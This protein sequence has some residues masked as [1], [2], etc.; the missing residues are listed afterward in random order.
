M[1][2]WGSFR[3]ALGELCRSLGEA[4]GSH[5]G[6][7]RLPINTLWGGF[8]VAW[9]GCIW[10]LQIADGK[11][12]IARPVALFGFSF[13]L[14]AFQLLPDCGFGWLARSPASISAFCF[15][16]SA[17]AWRRL[18]P[19]VQGSR[20]RV[21][22]S[23]F[24]VHHKNTEYNSPLP[25]PPGWSG[26]TLVPPWTYPGTIAPPQNPIFDQ[27]SL[28][29][30]VSCGSSTGQQCQGL[31]VGCWRLNVPRLFMHHVSFLALSA[32]TPLTFSR[33]MI[34]GSWLLQTPRSPGGSLGGARC[35]GRMRPS[36]S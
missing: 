31:D 34:P 18:C 11:W 4:L 23:R 21:Q 20:F 6:R 2:L 25:P 16:L 24:R 10:G 12:P 17:F 29:E 30:S 36:A 26:G 7:N 3:V 28:S 35:T 8:R 27:A 33:R 14:S 5:W 32:T 15:L 9:R 1:W 19:A 22:G 13:Q